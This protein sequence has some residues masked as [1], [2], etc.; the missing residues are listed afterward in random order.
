MANSELMDKAVKEG[1]DVSGNKPETPAPSTTDAKETVPSTVTP[2][3]TSAV[4]E[5]PSEAKPFV[6]GNQP[7]KERFEDNPGFKNV[8]RQRDSFK[9]ELQKAQEQNQKLMALL[10]AN[11]PKAEVGPQNEQEAAAKQLR[12]ILGIDNLVEKLESLDKRN[13]DFSERE[14]NQAFDKEQ[15]GIVKQCEKFGLDFNQVVPELQNYLDEHP[16]FSKIAIQ[17][18][19]YDLAFKAVYFDKSNDLAKRAAYAEQLKETEKLKKANS[20]AP[21]PGGATGSTPSYT[22]V[23]DL[24]RNRMDKEGGIS[25]PS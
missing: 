20:E 8:L 15:D 4:D 1:I 16:Y 24:V 12:Q 21:N 14:T 18:G 22:G 7:A 6:P 9:T 11:K 13:S 5:Q 2:E 19:F 23:K 10:E 25:F 17:P 3:K